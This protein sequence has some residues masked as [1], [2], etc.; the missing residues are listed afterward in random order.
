V[1][2][3]IVQLAEARH[4]I[5]AGTVGA[6][7]VRLSRDSALLAPGVDYAVSYDPARQWLLLTA[8]PL[9]SVFAVGEYE[10]VLSPGV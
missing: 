10:I 7:D 8:L 5:E 9:L 6:G 3:L 1:A 2:T 4:G